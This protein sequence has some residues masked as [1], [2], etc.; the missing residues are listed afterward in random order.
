[1]G[2]L[3]STTTLDQIEPGSNG[4]ERL[5]HIPQ[6]SRTGTLPSDGLVSYPGY[7]LGGGV[8]W[9]LAPLQRFSQHIVQPLLNGLDFL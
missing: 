4:N 9:D 8:L 2:P 1:M 6:S 5:L 7:S 3:T